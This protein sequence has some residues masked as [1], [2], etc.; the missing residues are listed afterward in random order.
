MASQEQMEFDYIVV[1]GGGAGAVLARTLAEQTAGTVGLLE[2]GPSDEGRP[3]VLDFRRYREVGQGPLARM[4]PIVAPAV[5]NGRFRYPTS[6]VLGGST[7]QNTCI[8]FRPP[9]SDFA[10]WVEAGAAGWGPAGVTPHFEALEARIRIEE[11]FPDEDSHRVLWRAAAEAGYPRTDFARPFDVGMGRYRMS[12]TG[13]QRQS[14][15]VV[16]LHPLDALPGNLAVITETEMRKLVF[17][18]GGAVVGVE[19]SRGLFRARREVVLAAGALDTPKLLMLSGIGPARHLAEH[20]IPVRRDLP[21]VGAHLLDH[22]AACVNV[23][24]RRPLARDAVWNYAGVAFARLEPGSPWPDIEM[25]LGAELFEQQTAPAG[26]PSA[27]HGFASYLTVNR[28]RSTGT[29]RLASR[30]A[31]DNPRVD[32]AYFTD[33]DGYDLRVMIAGIRESRRLFAAP[34]LAEWV[35]AELAPGVDCRDEGELGSYVR[36]T[37]TTGYHPAG[38]AVMGDAADPRAVVDPA[39]RVIG[40]PGLRIAD[41]SVFPTMVSVNIAATCMMVGHKAASLLRRDELS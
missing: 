41:A 34:A 25:Q 12:K 28:A 32:P 22:P 20:G 21:G 26:Y 27:P 38:T 3:E 2:A 16:F 6:R 30:E 11:E 35:G 1:G 15:S 8:W 37:A 4:I 29:V 40:V 17:G 13:T 10:D 5:G 14:T 36:E 23:A 39:L 33:R 19:T 9:A 31:G 18:D 24:A 7:S